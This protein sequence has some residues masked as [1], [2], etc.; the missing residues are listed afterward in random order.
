[1]ATGNGPIDGTPIARR[2]L[3]GVCAALEVAAWSV[4]KQAA[5]LVPDSY[6]G[7]VYRAGGAP[8]LLPVQ[9]DPEVLL[10]NVDGLLLVGGADVDPAVYG[11]ARDPRTETTVP[12][13]DAF[14]VALVRAAVV[15]EIPVLGICRGMQII[16]VA[17]G[18][19]LL[20]HVTDAEGQT[21][22]RRRMGGF[23]GADH[24][25]ALDDGS[26][27]ADAA[28]EG[29]HRVHCH[30]HQAIGALGAGLVISGRAEDGL[31]EALEAADGR[32]LLGVQWHPE[33]VNGGPVL[34][35]F[36]AACARFLEE[37]SGASTSRSE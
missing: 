13:R 23:D 4:W 21:T 14:E 31:P 36:V 17:F 11:A 25:V 7:D 20:Q 3:V 10:D 2:P 24:V 22:H 8:V 5:H 29:A 1:M 16:N 34:R 15:R 26:R 28:R 35:A 6:V 27:A 37:R 19:T 9:P 30:H 18:G 33:A 32:W 12:E